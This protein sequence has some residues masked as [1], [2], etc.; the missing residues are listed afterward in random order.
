MEALAC[1]V[2]KARELGVLEGLKL[3]NDGPVLTHMLY[4]DDALI[5][6][7]WNDRNINVTNGLL[8]IFYLCSGLQINIHKSVLFG[9]GVRDSEVSSMASLF[10]CKV[11]NLPFVYLGI[12]VGATMN[13][14][15]YWEPV[16]DTIRNRLSSWKSKLLSMGGR[17][18]L[19][20]S[21]LASLPVYYFSIFK[22][23]VKVV[24]EIEKMM[25][26]FLWCGCKE[27]RGMHWVALEVVTK[28]KKEGG[29][30][31]T[32]LSVINTAL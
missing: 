27:G 19:L 8:R 28:P 30:G 7:K 20:K 9:L 1:M 6:G 15:C 25:R 22:G 23:P 29:L 24:D 18:T 11:G 14:V 21:V 3:P 10:G 16:L 17:L 5:L 4:E 32:R 26:R 12:K 31:V 2:D 13:R